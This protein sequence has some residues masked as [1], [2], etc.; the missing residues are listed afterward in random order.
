MALFKIFKGNS[1]RLGAV[2]NTTEKT[3]EGNA[4]FTPDDG[5]FYIDITNGETPII[6][7][8]ENE[9]VDRQKVNRICINQR[10][11]NYSEFDILDCGSAEEFPDGA[12]E[13]IF[14]CQ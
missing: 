8:N 9:T 1:T 11:F 2:G 13:F 6:G 10:I 5:K 3:K 14:D 7:N 12:P 4:Y